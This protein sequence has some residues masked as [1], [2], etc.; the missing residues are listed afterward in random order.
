MQPKEE[1]KE[2]VAKEEAPGFKFELPFFEAV[3]QLPIFFYA[4][5]FP[6]TF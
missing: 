5:S 6:P 1:P 2:E 3:R 4:V